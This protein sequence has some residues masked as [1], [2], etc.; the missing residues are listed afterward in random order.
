[1]SLVADPAARQDLQN[2][3]TV[4]SIHLPTVHLSIPHLG[5]VG[6]VRPLDAVVETLLRLDLR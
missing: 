1:M 6:L 5:L 3:T 2:P 4:A